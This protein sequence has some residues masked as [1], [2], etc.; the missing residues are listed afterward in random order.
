MQIQH[1]IVINDFSYVDGGASQVA[2]S[3]ARGLANSGVNVTLF[4]AVDLADHTESSM[5]PNLRII[6]TNQKEIL[7]DPNRVRAVLQGL[8]NI[9]ARNQLKILLKSL[10]PER[11]IVHLHGW[12]KALSSSVIAIIREMGFKLVI[13]MHDY[14][15]ACPNGAFYNYVTG[16]LCNLEP[17]SLACFAENCDVRHYTHK[18]WRFGRSIIQKNIGMVPGGINYF[19]AVSDFSRRILETYLPKEAN[20][21]RLDNPIEMEKSAPAQVHMNQRYLMVGRIAEEK[22]PHLFAQAAKRLMLPAIFV[23]NGSLENVVTSIYPQAII[24]GWVNQDTVISHMR[25]ARALVF[26]SVLYESQPLVVLEAAALGLPAVVPDSSAARETVTDGVTGLWFKSQ[27]I[28]DLTEKLRLLC[29]DELVE[30]LGDQAYR[31]YWSS[32]RNLETHIKNLLDIYAD[33]MKR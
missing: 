1:V 30:K 21:Y 19:I 31:Q 25:S 32:P 14:F 18:L 23:G 6:S 22:G 24:T 4:C 10:D 5:P 16:K 28:D 29:Q 8:W 11:T 2:L 20:I 27:D 17:L 15:L 33:I 3:S 12:T 13:T 9:Q 26:A 7:N